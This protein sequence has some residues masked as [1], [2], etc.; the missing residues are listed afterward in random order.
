MVE[1]YWLGMALIFI[2][3]LF[4]GTF[5]LPMKYSRHWK[6]ENTWTVFSVVGIFALPW[7]MAYTLVPHLAEVYRAV[8]GRMLLLPLIFGFLWGFAQ[9]TY[10]L[11]L[12]AV[13]LAIA[14]SIVSGLAVISG[15]LVPL[16]VLNPADIL[17]SRG[18]L[19]LCSL[20]I[21]ILGLV[22][23]GVAGRLREKEQQAAGSEASSGGHSFRAGLAL[24]IFTGVF[25]ST[26]NLGYAFSGDIIK[27]SLQSGAGPATAGSA[28][29]S[30]VLGAGF[31]PN[32]FYCL[33]VLKRN[34][35]F[36]VFAQGR[37]AK[38][39]LLAVAMAVIWLSGLVL[40]GAGAIWAGKYGTSV[41][42]TV[43]IATSILSSSAVGLLAGEWRS[44][45]SRSKRLLAGG[46]AATLAA[47]VVLN[48]GGLF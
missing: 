7:V 25:G 47:V 15:S 11:S 21:L 30:L 43:F 10:G 40:Y 42:F 33:Y 19:L 12:N 41:G 36:P 45:S 3:G 1:K 5:A 46:L 27:A 31:L 18:I 28:V 39:T 17:R 35:T 4:N 16:L 20:P 13:G 9:T 22:L 6:W 2:S 32:F 26:F 44:T 34:R 24:C 38:D 8:P 48:L 14:V 23:Y 37:W 29:W